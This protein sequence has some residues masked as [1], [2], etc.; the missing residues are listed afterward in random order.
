VGQALAGV[1]IPD[2]ERFRF[3]TESMD[4]YVATYEAKSKCINPRDLS[5]DRPSRTV[6]CRNLAAATAD[7]LRIKMPDGKRRMLTEREGARL[8]SFP[9]W[10]IFTG[11]ESKR[12][13]QIG[14]AVAPLFAKAIGRAA[15]E[16]LACPDLT[17]DRI[18]Q[19]NE[20]D[21]QIRLYA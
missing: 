3:L 20:F 15:M 21:E 17:E 5:M 16:S 18:R 19:L 11:P 4:K 1:P 10:F 12:F 13:E 9:D 6:T 7:M 8:Q 2:A 14:N